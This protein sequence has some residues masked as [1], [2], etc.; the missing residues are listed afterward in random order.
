MSASVHIGL[1]YRTADEYLSAALPFLTDGLRAQEPVIVVATT[2][3]REA[4]RRG[5]GE[6]A[7]RCRFEESAGWYDTPARAM[8]RYL[9]LW[10]ERRE[11]GAASLRIL[12]E[13]LA[14]PVTPARIERWTVFENSVN[15]VLASMPF[16]MM[17]SYDVSA[18]QLD[19]SIA[20]SHPYLARDGAISTNDCFVEP[21]EFERRHLATPLP[22]AASG[23]QTTAFDI[24]SA[25]RARDV[26]RR[27]AAL[28][29]MPPPRIDEVVIAV[30]EA[31]ANAIEHGG[32]GGTLT[33]FRSGDELICDITSRA[34][35]V[36]DAMRGYLLPDASAPRGRG[37]W[38]MRQLC[39]W[40]ELRGPTVRVHNVL[41]SA[42]CMA[43]NA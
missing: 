11:R 39:D 4:I 22:L 9:D 21:L 38:I 2:P 25:W 18:P 33:I 20:C 19:E 35:G 37:L 12:A 15:A 5:L 28:H 13:P 17:C 32:G 3:Q 6:K 14:T 42:S 16:M 43:S 27:Y 1:P 36:P 23:R 24:E 34:G 26:L 7:E 10:R 41:S 8:T 29:G 30:G 31:L 40:V